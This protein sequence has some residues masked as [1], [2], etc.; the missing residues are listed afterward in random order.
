MAYLPAKENK[1][2]THEI[3]E[4]PYSQLIIEPELQSKKEDQQEGTHLSASGITILFILSYG[5]G[6]PSKAFRRSNAAAP[7]FVLW[8]IILQQHKQTLHQRLVEETQD[9]L[10]SLETSR[11]TPN[12]KHQSIN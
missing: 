1:K 12:H 9:F 11:R 2:N 6:I 5:A 10:L 7:R 8:G 3:L 4:S